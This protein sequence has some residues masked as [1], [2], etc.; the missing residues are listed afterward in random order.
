MDEQLGTLFDFIRSD[1]SL[2]DNT[3]I[4]MCS[5]NGPELGAGSAGHLRGHKTTLYEGGV[6]SPLVVWGPGLISEENTGSTNEESVFAAFDLVPSLLQIAGVRAPENV[7]FDGQAL[8]KV[9]LGEST[10][11][12]DGPICFRRPPDRPAIQKK[13]L[14]DLAVR[15]GKWKLLCSY[16]GSDVQLYDLERNPGERK[17]LA[18]SHPKIV[19]RL[20]ATILDWHAKMPADNGLDWEPK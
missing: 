7:E 20:T 1:E 2:K 14:P 17:N 13:Q 10:E 19:E 6:R 3:L 16:D 4:V 18:E 15:D 11:S 5:D 12:H 8:P 9:L